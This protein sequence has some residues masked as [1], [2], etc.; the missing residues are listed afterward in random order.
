PTALAASHPAALHRGDSGARS[1]SARLGPPRSG[2]SKLSGSA[3]QGR[4]DRAQSARAT[5]RV[6][7]APVVAL[8]LAA[9]LALP[10]AAVALPAAADLAALVGPLL[11]DLR[12]QA[13]RW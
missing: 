1:P 5:F 11:E 4:R 2:R 10:A 6:R 8:R 12:I 13:R 9:R 7:L 3:P